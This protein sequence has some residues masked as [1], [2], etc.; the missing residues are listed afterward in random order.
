MDPRTPNPPVLPSGTKSSLG[1][2]TRGQLPTGS[3]D[4]YPAAMGQNGSYP[5][6]NYKRW[7]SV[8]EHQPMDY[9]GG[10]NE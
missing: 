8:V 9:S 5:N 6:Q 1:S 3:R 10:R 4:P 2:T 7:A